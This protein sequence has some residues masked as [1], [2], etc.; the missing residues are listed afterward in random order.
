MTTPAQ[1]RTRAVAGISPGARDTMIQS[2]SGENCPHCNQPCT[3]KARGPTRFRIMS[4]APG[5]KWNHCWNPR[6][7]SMADKILESRIRIFI[8]V[9]VNFSISPYIT[10]H[11]MYKSLFS[12]QV[13]L[14]S[15]QESRNQAMIPMW[16]QITL[17]KI[18]SG[19]P[20]VL[21]PL[22][23]GVM[24]FIS[25]RIGFSLPHFFTI[26]YYKNHTP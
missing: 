11:V 9:P 10:N 17:M 21:R 13:S 23:G 1:K 14:E 5:I 15:N 7:T 8:I 16:F 18:D 3:T 24:L 12:K 26:S 6:I 22:F 25:A 2:L 19:G 4:I 20:L